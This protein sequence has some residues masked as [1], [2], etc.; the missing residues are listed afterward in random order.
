MAFKDQELEQLSQS[1]INRAIFRIEPSL[2]SPPIIRR[3]VEVARERMGI[4][5]FAP[6]SVPERQPVYRREP[7]KLMYPR[8]APKPTTRM[9]PLKPFTPTLK[10]FEEYK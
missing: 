3:L 6:Y 8:P 4:Q 10:P 9:A 5:S 7:P 1:I 2:S